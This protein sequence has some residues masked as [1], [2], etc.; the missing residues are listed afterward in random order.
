[1]VCHDHC[2]SARTD[3]Q[4]TC[5]KRD[6]NHSNK[7][8]SKAVKV[9]TDQRGNVLQVPLLGKGLS[10]AVGVAGWSSSGGSKGPGLSGFPTGPLATWRRLLRPK[11][12][13]PRGCGDA[14][15]ADSS[16]PCTACQ[17]T[18]GRFK[19][20]AMLSDLPHKAGGTPG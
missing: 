1:M 6:L 20:V 14:L 3:V 4:V 2:L 5:N 12:P 10:L 19:E 13:Q 18:S 15:R 8:L 7:V 11:Q 16:P 17:I 9:I